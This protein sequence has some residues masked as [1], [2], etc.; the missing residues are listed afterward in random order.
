MSDFKHV[1]LEM[2]LKPFKETTE[3]YIDSVVRKAFGQWHSLTANAVEI[4]VLLWVSDGSELLDWNGDME[5]EFEW[6]YYIGGANN[7][8]GWDKEADPE[9]IGLHSTRYKYIPNP[10]KMTYGILKNIISAIKKIG[11]ELN[12]GKKIRVGETFDPGPEFAV[13]DFKYKRHRECCMAGTMGAKS[14]LCCYAVMNGDDRHYASF[15]NGVPDGTSFGT[16]FGRQSRS[17]LT[18]MG[19]DYLWLS[20]GFGFG[21]EPWAATGAVFDGENFIVSK[22]DEIKEKALGFWRDF[23]KEC[24]EYRIETR[25]TNLSVAIDL[26]TDG[27]P[28]KDIYNGDFNILPPPN[29]PWAALNGDYGLELA[30]YM[31]R[32][33][34]IPADEYLFRYYVHDPWWLNSPWQDRYEGMPHDIYLPMAVSRTDENGDIM[35]PTHFN[36][37]SIDN[38]LGELPEHCASEPVSHIKKALRYAPDRISPLLWVYP[39]DEYHSYADE[40]SI[41]EMFFEDWFVRGAINHGLPLSTVISTANFVKAFKSN[42]DKFSSSVLV[43]TVPQKDSEYENAILGFI[44]KGGRVIFYG[45]ADRASDS[46]KALVNIKTVSDGS[47]GEFSIRVADDIDNS[48]LAKSDKILHRAL[49]SGG[50]LNTVLADENASVRAL[51]YADDYAVLTVAENYAWLR[52]TCSAEFTGGHL[53]EPDSEDRYYSG[54]SLMRYALAKLGY[55]IAFDKKDITSREPVI[56]LHRHENAYIFSLALADTTVGVRM[57][58]PL[59]AP[60][61]C[62]IDSYIDKDGFACYNFGKWDF[63]ECRVFV[64]QEESGVIGCHEIAP[65]SYQMSRRIKLTGLRNAT[66]RFLAPDWCIDKAEGALN[67]KE[68]YYI[69]GDSFEASFVQS[70]GEYYFEAKN[71]TG[72]LVLSIPFKNPLPPYC[73]E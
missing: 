41:K 62:G 73:K 57:K 2:S 12:P 5:S 40:D 17:F 47:S 20:N 49:C 6:A 58:F 16:F 35:L 44:K 22:F 23:R 30:G 54:E 27:V 71:V 34:H 51:V 13:S 65:V 24:P 59:G 21:M 43:S 52:G 9:R 50:G 14:M 10:P 56:M 31:S 48:A 63:K 37:L 42:G 32:I 8:E 33:S 11:L 68:D 26:A 4:S 46:F 18:D 3:E 29:S 15:P 25:G 7:I 19:F 28:L 67:S 1:T 53:L 61:L 45:S 38:S 72:E 64:E 69:T 70:E 39:F 55:Q 60:V 36:V 66:V